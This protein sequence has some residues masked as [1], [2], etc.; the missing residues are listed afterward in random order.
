[1]GVITIGAFAGQGPRTSPSLLQDNQAVR[2]VNCNL[3]SGEIRAFK[4]TARSWKPTKAGYLET[5]CLYEGSY[6]LHWTTDV[7]VAHGP[8][9]DDDAK[10]LYFT[11][12]GAPKM[13]TLA[14][15]TQGEGTDYPLA[16][17]PLGIPA[18]DSADAPKPLIVTPGGGVTVNARSVTYVYTYVSDLGEEGPPNAASEVTTTHNGETVGLSGF[19]APPAGYGYVTR[20]RIYRAA[21]GSSGNTKFQFVAEVPSDTTT[22][23][24]QVLDKNLGEVLPSAGWKQPPENLRGL[25]SMPGGIFAGFF[26]KTVCLCEPYYPHAWPLGY[27]YTVDY[28]IVGL[29]V[30]GTTLA[31]LTQAHPYLMAVSHPSVVQI[32]KHPNPQGCVSKQGIVSSELGVIFPTSDGLF[33]LS[34]RE[35]GLMTRDLVTKNDW[36]KFNP[37]TLHAVVHDGRYWGFYRTEVTAAGEILGGG[38]VI[39]PQEP[40]VRFTS[41]DFYAHCARVIPETDDL[42]FVFRVEGVNSIDKWDSGTAPRP[43]VWQSKHFDMSPRNFAAARLEANFQVPL[44]PEEIAQR[45]G[46]RQEAITA[47]QALLDGYFDADGK[48]LA[49]VDGGLGMA[50]LAD[51]LFA[52]DR[53]RTPPVV[54]ISQRYVDFTLIVDDVVRFTHRVQDSSPFRLPGGYTGRKVQLEISGTADVKKVLIGTSIASLAV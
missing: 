28:P 46:L 4:D 10:R 36:A 51:V 26:G 52:G 47:N 39:D 6:W 11:G 27:R 35:S 23:N 32:Q 44:T 1:M 5:I 21:T 34:D 40:A 16:S 18:P 53:L 14:L 7:D 41:V 48:V 54:D 13:T 31:V 49:G 24:D 30:Y 17:R 3:F 12:E 22:W 38:F 37:S 29:G 9:V 8:I 20:F 45:E 15:A 50:P 33:L 19:T 25:V 2:A 43:Y 42:Y